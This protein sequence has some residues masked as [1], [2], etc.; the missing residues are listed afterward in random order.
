M[1][2]KKKTIIAICFPACVQQP[3]HSMKAWVFTSCKGRASQQSLG[4]SL[5]IQPWQAWPDPELGTLTCFKSLSMASRC[6]VVDANVQ[7]P[8]TYLF[9]VSELLSSLQR[10]DQEFNYCKYFVYVIWD[11]QISWRLCF[12]RTLNKWNKKCKTLYDN[13]PTATRRNIQGN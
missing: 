12:C 8:T 7:C 1:E 9:V 3:P 11:E 2:K 13:L 5:M 6:Y 4:D 10:L